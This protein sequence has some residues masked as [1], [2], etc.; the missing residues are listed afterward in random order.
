[1]FTAFLLDPELKPSCDR[2]DHTQWAIAQHPIL[3]R[4][5][6]NCKGTGVKSQDVKCWIS[7]V[8]MKGNTLTLYATLIKVTSI[9]TFVIIYFFGSGYGLSVRLRK[10]R[11]SD[12]TLQHQRTSGNIT[13]SD[14]CVWKGTGMRFFDV[15]FIML[16]IF[17]SLVRQ[18]ILIATQIRT[19]KTLFTCTQ[20]SD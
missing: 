2:S 20:P 14:G 17:I 5:H 1:M 7:W 18:K 6:S 13:E 15:I 12:Q 4:L 9:R 10:R 11:G 8:T 19:L 3:D 16:V